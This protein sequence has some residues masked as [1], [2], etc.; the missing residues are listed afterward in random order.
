MCEFF[1]ADSGV[2]QVSAADRRF[3]AWRVD[4][5]SQGIV[6]R[7][8]KTSARSELGREGCHEG[9]WIRFVWHVS[10]GLSIQEK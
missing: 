6:R 5:N 10:G 7:E 8:L 9:A 2:R 4:V 1:D 3:R